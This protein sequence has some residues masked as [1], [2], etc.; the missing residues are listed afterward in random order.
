MDDRSKSGRSDRVRTA[1]LVGSALFVLAFVGI[2]FVGQDAASSAYDPEFDPS[3]LTQR[4]Y[5][6]TWAPWARGLLWLAA[7]TVAVVFNLAFA[8][9]PELSER[10]RKL[11]QAAAVVSGATFLAFSIGSFAGADWSVIH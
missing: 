1:I 4:I 8:T 10:G 6:G 5:P 7:G 2:W 3:T 11:A 9:T